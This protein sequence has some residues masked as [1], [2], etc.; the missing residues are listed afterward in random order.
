M[1]RKLGAEIWGNIGIKYI[2]MYSGDLELDS[3]SVRFNWELV[4][5]LP[6]N[7]KGEPKNDNMGRK[8][9]IPEK[10]KS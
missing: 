9:K 2:L 7:S 4:L 1:Y 8:W 6:L 3:K 5:S 10:K